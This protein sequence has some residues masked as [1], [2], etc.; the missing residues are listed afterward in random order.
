MKHA[1]SKIDN[2]ATFRRATPAIHAALAN[3]SSGGTNTTS[4][5]A[6]KGGNPFQVSS[7][8]KNAGRSD[9]L[10][11]PSTSMVDMPTQAKTALCCGA[12]LFIASCG[13]RARIYGS[14]AVVA[15]QRVREEPAADLV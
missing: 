3:S 11:A 12:S 15:D 2:H 13:G 8:S 6:A 14:R 7:A 9:A 1:T 10:S 4:A 5:T